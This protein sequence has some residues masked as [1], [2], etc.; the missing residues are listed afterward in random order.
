MFKKMLLFLTC[1]GMVCCTN[2]LDNIDDAE[3][4]IIQP[5]DS[6]VSGD[7][8]GAVDIYNFDIDV[9][10]II[11][12]TPVTWNQ[13]GT[14][15]SYHPCN[16]ILKDQNGDSFQL[17]DHYGKAIVL[18]FSAGWC[19]PCR[20]AA[21]STQ[22]HYDHYIGKGLLYATVLIEDTERNVPD[23]EDARRWAEDHNITTAPVLVGSRSML[24]SSEGSWRLTGW[25]TFYLIDRE[26]EMYV[27]VRGWNEEY[28]FDYIDE[29]L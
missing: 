26:M 12:N 17:Y 19:G 6:N 22:E 3:D 2:N 24:E 9:S 1:I 23:V 13:C 15:P 27:I 16:F 18:D 4:I 20:A 25:P 14:R 8:E 5:P 11:G 28:L 21:Y 7:E 10:N 29:L